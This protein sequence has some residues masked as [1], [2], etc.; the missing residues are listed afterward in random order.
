MKH[1]Y[2]LWTGHGFVL[3]LLGE[4]IR[5]LVGNIRGMPEF[6]LLLVLAAM[7][8]LVLN[9]F[10]W[11]ALGKNVDD[12]ATIAKVDT[13]V[14]ANYCILVLFELVSLRL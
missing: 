6:S 12:S 11:W 7:T 4:G 9:H 1:R 5:W 14:V 10:R 2:M 3:L 8:I 13:L